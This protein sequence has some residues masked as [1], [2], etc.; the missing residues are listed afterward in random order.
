MKSLV[1]SPARGFEHYPAQSIVLCNACGLPLFKLEAGIGLGQKMGR[2]AQLFKPIRQADLLELRDRV[3]I[4]AGVR[5]KIASMTPDEQQAHLA[6][7]TEPKAGDPMVCPAC[8]G[9]FAQVLTV[10]RSE[11]LDRAYVVEFLTIPPFGAGKPTPM[12]GKRI[13]GERGEW[14]H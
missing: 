9:C 12:R 6:C 2:A 13:D 1:E 11:T 4:D 7:L 10:E 14:V 5:A 8:G 3:D